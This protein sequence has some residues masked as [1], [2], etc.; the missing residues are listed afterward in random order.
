MPILLFAL[1][2]KGSH[3]GWFF[4]IKAVILWF[5]VSTLVGLFISQFKPPVLKLRRTVDKDAPPS[6]FDK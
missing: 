4:S 5:I 1:V 3:E 6:M 2:T